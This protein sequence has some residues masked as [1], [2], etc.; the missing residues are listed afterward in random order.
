MSLT[1]HDDKSLN[2]LRLMALGLAGF[3]LVKAYKKEGSLLGATGK[4]KPLNFNTNKIVDAIMPFVDIPET[5][6][7]IVS[8]GL[9]EFAYN[10]KEE[11]L[12]RKE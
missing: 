4:D 3:Y 8:E 12:K 5:Q 1:P 6:K 9:K 11:I 10:L 7:G 2:I